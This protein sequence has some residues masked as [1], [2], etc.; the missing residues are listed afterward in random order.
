MFLFEPRHFAAAKAKIS[1]LRS[2]RHKEKLFLK[3]ERQSRNNL[4]FK[5][6]SYFWDVLPQGSPLF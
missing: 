5:R 6:T 3:E 4:I 1:S 2:H